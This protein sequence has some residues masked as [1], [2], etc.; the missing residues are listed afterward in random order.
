MRKVDVFQ[1]VL[2]LLPEHEE[3]LGFRE[4][5]ERCH[6]QG[7]LEARRK[8]ARDIL[9]DN[10]FREYA[11]DMGYEIKEGVGKR[12]AR[13]FSKK[14]LK[15]EEV[16]QYDYKDI[17]E[18]IYFSNWL[19]PASL[20]SLG[21][22]AKNYVLEKL[23]YWQEITDDTKWA[24]P[25]SV[26]DKAVFATNW[27][28]CQYTNSH[29]QY[30]KNFVTAIYEKK[31]ITLK[32]IA[33]NSSEAVDTI[34]YRLPNKFIPVRLCYHRGTLYFL[35]YRPNNEQIFL[36]ELESVE[37]CYTASTDGRFT[38]SWSKE[39]INELFS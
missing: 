16:K 26:F 36:F 13:L 28:E 32:V 24:I 38:E 4:I 5:G 22:T 30:V 17:V 27:G 21:Q 29:L 25:P 6:F 35:V 1:R 18:S 10:N 15:A 37:Q 33:Y 8:K 31:Y 20:Q 34:D 12:K 39:I 9:E 3:G 7:T 11:Q 19:M 23:P 2:K 14:K